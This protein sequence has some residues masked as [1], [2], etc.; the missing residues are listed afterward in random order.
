MAFAP[1]VNDK[2][3]LCSRFLV[4]PVFVMFFHQ[5]FW[6]EALQRRVP[7]LLRAL[8]HPTDLRWSGGESEISGL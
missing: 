2:V 4:S 6:A 3:Y 1:G 5:L 7:L 8:I